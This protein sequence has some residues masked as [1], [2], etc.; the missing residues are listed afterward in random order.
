VPKILGGVVL[1]T[2][3]ANGKKNREEKMSIEVWVRIELVAKSAMFFTPNKPI[4][5]TA[6][7]LISLPSILQWIVS[8][9]QYWFRVIE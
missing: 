6:Y 9:K 4:L 3:L 1:D 8:L 5:A 7:T 2:A